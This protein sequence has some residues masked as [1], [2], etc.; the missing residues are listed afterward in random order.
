MGQRITEQDT[1][2]AS[3][4]VSLVRELRREFRAMLAQ[5]SADLAGSLAMLG[6]PARG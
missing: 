3:S 2:A 5:S 1:S 6:Q 4:Q